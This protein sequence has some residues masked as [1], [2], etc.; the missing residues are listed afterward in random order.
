MKQPSYLFCVRCKV[1]DVVYCK[2]K[3]NRALSV[4]PEINDFFVF[5]VFNL[6]IMSLSYILEFRFI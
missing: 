3:A 6:N 4:K 5:H 2:V 1:C